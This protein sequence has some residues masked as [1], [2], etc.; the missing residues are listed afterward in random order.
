MTNVARSIGRL[1][2]SIPA[3]A[4]PNRAQAAWRRGKC[5]TDCAI[6]PTG[7]AWPA[8]SRVIARRLAAIAS[9]VTAASKRQADC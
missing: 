1:R 9:A 2:L 6:S 3:Y 5:P 7:R 8:I 4:N